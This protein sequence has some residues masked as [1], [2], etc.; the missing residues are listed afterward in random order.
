MSSYRIEFSRL[1]RTHQPPAIDFDSDAAE[2]PLMDELVLRID[3]HARK[4]LG[5]RDI[6]VVLDT[7]GT[8]FVLAGVRNAGNFQVL[9]AVQP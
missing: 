7:D 5:S 6:S 3:Q 1:G 9:E 4:Y 8:G 2:E